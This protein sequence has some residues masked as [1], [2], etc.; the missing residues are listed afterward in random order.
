MEKCLKK[1]IMKMKK[2]NQ[3]LLLVIGTDQRGTLLLKGELYIGY[4]VC[5][6]AIDR[7]KIQVHRKCSAV[8]ISEIF[9]HRHSIVLMHFLMNHLINHLLLRTN[10][11]LMYQCT[12][13]KRGLSLL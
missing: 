12:M 2:E 13:Q 4:T 6:T 1:K 10:L 3:V 8:L 7:G 5:S 11:N 9:C